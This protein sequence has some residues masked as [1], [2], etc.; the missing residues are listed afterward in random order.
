MGPRPI[1][2]RRT[3]GTPRPLKS[4]HF[5]AA[6]HCSPPLIGCFQ[7]SPA[8]TTDPERPPAPGR[9]EDQARPPFPPPAQTGRAS[10]CRSSVEGSRGSADRGNTPW[11]LS[12]KGSSTVAAKRL[13]SRFIRSELISI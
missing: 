12:M 8:R 11:S 5:T 1:T 7:L 2:S 4:C 13:L 6:V 9:D 10:V 3:D